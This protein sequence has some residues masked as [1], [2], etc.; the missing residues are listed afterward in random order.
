MATLSIEEAQRIL[1]DN[2]SPWV[3]ELDMRV[4]QVDAD[5]VRVRMPYNQRL[6]HSGGVICGQALMGIADAAMLVAIANA[7]PGMTAR[8]TVSLNISF[9]RPAA[10]TDVIADIRILKSGRTLAFGDVTLYGADPGKPLAQLSVTYVVGQ[11]D[12]GGG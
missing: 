2:I 4:E 8:A 10:E 6:V 3:G 12:G 11:K 7:A 1:D 5:V 9:L